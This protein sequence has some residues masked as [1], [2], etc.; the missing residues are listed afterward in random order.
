[1]IKEYHQ[2]AKRFK[3]RQ[4]AKFAKNLSK[5]ANLFNLNIVSN[6]LLPMFIQLSD[7]KNQTVCQEV[8]PALAPI[9]MKYAGD[10][11]LPS[12]VTIM[13]KNF[14]FGTYKQR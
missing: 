3:W 1:V 2:E 5:Y 11:R 6:D 10:E 7:D 12:I 14:R 4:K 8:A 9:L 13:R